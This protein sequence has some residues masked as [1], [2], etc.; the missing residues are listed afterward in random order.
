MKRDFLD[1]YLTTFSEVV[2]SETKN[3]WGSSFFPKDLEFNLDFKNA[4]KNWEKVFCFWD[5]SI[6]IGIV[7]L[8]LLRKGY[9]S[10]AANAL[11]TRLKIWDVNNRDFFQLNWVGSDHLKAQ[12]CC[13]GDFN[14]DLARL[15]YS[16]SKRP[17]K[18]DFLDIY[19]TTFF[20]VVISEIKNLW[21]SSFF[22]KDL[23]F[24]LDLKN[25]AKN[26]E[27]VFCFWDNCIWI[28]TVNCLS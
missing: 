15:P 16:L 8:S 6:R 28:G 3:L 7:K 12:M 25:A 4:A 9:C 26:W 18:Q 17:L 11:I 27:K 10:S 22:P 24:T 19:L 1:I 13:D 20:K 5:N 2:V 21:G 14:S 23:E